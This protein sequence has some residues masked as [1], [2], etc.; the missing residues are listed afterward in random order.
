MKQLLIGVVFFFM[1]QC[2]GCYWS[3]QPVYL[4]YRRPANVPLD[5]VLV[6]LAKGGV[7]QRCE[8]VS[9]TGQT[10]CQIFT[11]KGGLLYDEIFLPYDQGPTPEAPDLKIPSYVP[12]VGSDWVCLQNGRILL[13]MSRFDELKAFLSKGSSKDGTR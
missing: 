5:A 8:A 2:T 13:P 1:L 7:W 4:E 9:T 11:W 12:A 10:R 6:Q 3:N